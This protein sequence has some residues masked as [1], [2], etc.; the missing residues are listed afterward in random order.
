MWSNYFP[1]QTF[2]L[3]TVT[4]LLMIS[5]GLEFKTSVFQVKMMPRMGHTKFLILILLKTFG[6]LMVLTWLEKNCLLESVTTILRVWVC[7]E[8]KTSIFSSSNKA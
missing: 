7:H 4:T 3:V 2:L 1:V 6:L 5:H 8:R